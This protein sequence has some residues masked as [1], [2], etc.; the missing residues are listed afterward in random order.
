MKTRDA[1]SRD[2]RLVRG[3]R[4]RRAGGW[5]IG[6]P[7]Q[8]R[9]RVDAAKLPSGCT[10][11]GAVALRLVQSRSCRAATRVGDARDHRHLPALPR[12]P[13]QRGRDPAR[14]RL[15]R[16]GRGSARGVA[17]GGGAATVGSG[18]PSRAEAAVSG[19]AKLTAR[20]D[21]SDA[22][23]CAEGRAV[24]RSGALPRIRAARGA[25]SRT[26]RVDDGSI[27]A[28][29]ALERD[30]GW[31]EACSCD[32]AS[33]RRGGAVR[34]GAGVGAQKSH[35]VAPWRC[36]WCGRDRE[37]EAT[38]RTPTETTG[39]CDGCLRAQRGAAGKRATGA[40]PA[41]L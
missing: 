3:L 29:V 15:P 24:R 10:P 21:A 22:A 26:R 6:S 4:C 16:L 30:P 39:I 12:Q 2:A 23:A 19:A 7:R 18:C 37:G 35:R 38:G 13:V 32:E 33:P 41:L 14:T 34:T 40:E 9:D 11:H 8:R 17:L 5:S 36:G 1:R 31:Y 27:G 25:E 20:I 28:P